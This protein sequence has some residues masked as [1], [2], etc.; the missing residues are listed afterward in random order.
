M[1]TY[2]A[3]G[4]AYAAMD[5][6]EIEEHC[7]EGKD[8]NPPEKQRSREEKDRDWERQKGRILKQ[9]PSTGDYRIRYPRYSADLTI[10][11]KKYE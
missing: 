5:E 2:R 3:Q 1:E 8:Y 4:G 6:W 9:C 7:E 10:I 11:L